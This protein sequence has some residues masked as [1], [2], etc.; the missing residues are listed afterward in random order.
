[1]IKEYEAFIDAFRVGKSI[2]NAAQ[3]KQY[4]TVANLIGQLLISL[5]VIS[6]GFGYHIPV[7]DADLLKAG[8]ALGTFYCIGNYV[9]TMITSEKIGF[10]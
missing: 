1:M 4:Q 8:S 5:A 2:K 9:L 10:K 7:S 3:A 6:Q